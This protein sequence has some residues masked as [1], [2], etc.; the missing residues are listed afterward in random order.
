MCK[1]G[2][3]PH[4]FSGRRWAN[5]KSAF[6]QRR[7]EFPANTRQWAIVGSMLVHRLRRRPNIQPKKLYFLVFA[8][9]PERAGALG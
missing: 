2:L 1:G 6:D 7:V 8:E 5:I 3:K 4:L 9:T